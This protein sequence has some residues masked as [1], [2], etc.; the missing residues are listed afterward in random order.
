MTTPAIANPS[1]L[2]LF[3]TPTA[4]VPKCLYAGTDWVGQPYVYLDGSSVALRSQLGQGITSD[5][6]FGV[7]ISGPIGIFETLEN[8]H[9]GGGYWTFNP[10]QLESLASSASIPVPTFI[11]ST[12]RLLYAAQQVSNSVSML[13]A[14]DPSIPAGL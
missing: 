3:P 10:V 4:I 9:I 2:P 7:T 1:Q 5:N 14:A 11:P 8:M 13:Q 12:P 6:V